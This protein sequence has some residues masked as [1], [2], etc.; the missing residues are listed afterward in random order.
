MNLKVEV[1]TSSGETAL[2][3]VDVPKGSTLLEAL[4]LLGEENVA[5]T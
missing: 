1:V 4:G 2:Y 5:F 3:S